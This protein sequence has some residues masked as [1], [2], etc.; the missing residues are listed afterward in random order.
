MAYF[1]QGEADR[2]GRMLAAVRRLPVLTVGEGSAS[3]NRAG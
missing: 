2:Q 1:A 3:S